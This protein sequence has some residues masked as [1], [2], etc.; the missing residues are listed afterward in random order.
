MNLNKLPDTSLNTAAQQSL[1]QVEDSAASETAPS[2]ASVKSE[3]TNSDGTK[4]T[5]TFTSNPEVTEGCGIRGKGVD[6]KVKEYMAFPEPGETN[7]TAKVDSAIENL[8]FA[9]KQIL[10]AHGKQEITAKDLLKDDGRKISAEEIL[11]DDGRKVSAEEI[12]EDDGRKVSAEEILED[13]G[14]KISAQEIIESTAADTLS[15]DKRKI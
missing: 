15:N 7:F 6:Q 11:Q 2:S 10:A 9:E 3:L 13:D 5:R 14:R 12:L 1:G 4:I 8:G